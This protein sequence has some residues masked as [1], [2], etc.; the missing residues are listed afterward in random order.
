MDFCS[1]L[2]PDFPTYDRPVHPMTAGPGCGMCSVIID[3]EY[4][5]KI[6][7]G[8]HEK[9]GLNAFKPTYVKKFL[10]NSKRLSCCIEIQDFMNE[11]T[12]QI[13]QNKYP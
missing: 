7:F 3:D 4:A 6:Y 10:L 1:S 9:A 5:P 11:I 2:D 12:L 8:D 13:G